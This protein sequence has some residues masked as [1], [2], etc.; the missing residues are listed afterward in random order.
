MKNKILPKRLSISILFLLFPILIWSQE[1]NLNNEFTNSAIL[2]LVEDGNGYLYIA[3]IKG[4]I[5]YGG[6]E[7][8]EKL[9]PNGLDNWLTSIARHDATNRY[10]IG[11]RKGLWVGREKNGEFSDIDISNKNLPKRKVRDLILIKDT[12]YIGF[13]GNN[14]DELFI[15]KYS[16]KS[17]S[18]INNKP[19]ESNFIGEIFMF[20]TESNRLIVFNKHKI[21]Y[22]GVEGDISVVDSTELEFSSPFAIGDSL[23]YYNGD[24]QKSKKLKKLSNS[25]TKISEDNELLRYLKSQN[26]T[27]HRIIEGKDN[28]IWICTYG[29]GLFEYRPEQQL[30]KSYKSES[31]IWSVYAGDTIKLVGTESGLQNLIS[32]KYKDPRIFTEKSTKVKTIIPIGN[33]NNATQF[34]IGEQDGEIFRYN[35]SYKESTILEYDKV[36]N[37]AFCYY[38]DSSSNSNSKDTILIGTNTGVYYTTDNKTLNKYKVDTQE[39]VRAITRTK[40]SKSLLIGTKKGSIFLDGKKREIKTSKD[41]SY[42]NLFILCLYDIGQD[43]ILMGTEGGG[44]FKFNINDNPLNLIPI[45]E[46]RLKDESIYKIIKDRNRNFWLPSSNNLYRLNSKLDTLFHY[47]ERWGVSREDYNFLDFYKEGEDASQDTIYIGGGNSLDYFNPQVLIEQTSNIDPPKLIGELSLKNDTLIELKKGEN[48]SIKIYPKYPSLSNKTIF[49]RKEKKQSHYQHFCF[50]PRHNSSQEIP[51]QKP[52]EDLINRNL[53]GEKIGILNIEITHINPTTGLPFDAT[54]VYEIDVDDYLSNKRWF[55]FLIYSIPLGVIFIIMRI[56]KHFDNKQRQLEKERRQSEEKQKQL[57]KERKQSKIILDQ[58]IALRE[59]KEI[60]KFAIDVATGIAEKRGFINTFTEVREHLAKAMP[61]YAFGIAIYNEEKGMLEYKYWDE[62]TDEG[63]KADLYLTKRDFKLNESTIFAASLYEKSDEGT[64][65]NHEKIIK[66]IDNSS[67]SIKRNKS[68]GGYAKSLIFLPLDIEENNHKKRIA[69]Y[70]IQSSSK[71]KNSIYSELHKKKAKSLQII[72]AKTL[73]GML[74]NDVLP[75]N[76]P[77]GNFL[78]D[79]HY[80]SPIILGHQPS[81]HDSRMGGSRFDCIIHKRFFYTELLNNKDLK[82]LLNNIGFSEDQIV[83]LYTKAIQKSLEV[84]L[85]SDSNDILNGLIESIQKQEKEHVRNEKKK[86]LKI[87]ELKI[88]DKYRL[89]QVLTFL[90]NEDYQEK[91]L[92]LYNGFFVDS[93]KTIQKN[94]LNLFTIFLIA[95]SVLRSKKETFWKEIIVDSCDELMTSIDK[96]FSN[97]LTL[98]L[99]DP[100]IVDNDV[101]ISYK[102]K[103]PIKKE[104]ELMQGILEQIHIV[105]ETLFFYD[106]KDGLEEKDS[107]ILKNISF[108]KKARQL[109]FE[110]ILNNSDLNKLVNKKKALSLKGER[111]PNATSN[112][113][114]ALETIVENMDIGTWFTFTSQQINTNKGSIILTFKS[115]HS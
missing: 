48:R 5:R 37:S 110:I 102:T 98:P 42:S 47:D 80:T 11:T 75:S 82:A 107:L 71:E 1:L 72:L 106:S 90:I 22:L 25:S 23:I 61:L 93:L 21:A 8:I 63:F 17:D 85:P 96:G 70:T 41:S 84:Y 57:E 2:D 62:K 31:T 87:P 27:A 45:Y 35:A 64:F 101:E 59:E 105:F 43:T 54:D 83:K 50:L 4:L 55:W 38:M 14:K 16:I 13:E 108:K 100:N 49:R 69:A 15:Y 34:L 65:L 24:I 73:S 95:N 39:E 7:G 29:Q 32:E 40:T 10:F 89:E 109:S 103:E 18:I 6:V 114:L 68:M 88:G 91:L 28:S 44:L 36:V 20:K 12:L 52:E 56:K 33:K 92:F 66:D 86:L 9:R 94:N 77:I 79:L 115:F 99:H 97:W 58:N 104:W 3:T 111:G 81:F 30:V 112:A 78:I 76:Y 53:G 19:Y 74:K 26:I 67:F 51:K 60:R 113:L 46:T